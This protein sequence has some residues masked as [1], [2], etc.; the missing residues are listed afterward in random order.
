MNKS[1]TIDSSILKNRLKTESQ[2]TVKFMV[3]PFS[4]DLIRVWKSTYIKPNNSDEV[5][6]LIDKF[7]IAFFP[8]W[9]KIDVCKIT[10]FTLVFEGLPKNCKSFDLIEDALEDGG[11]HFKNIKRNANDVYILEI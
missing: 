5:Y 7:N 6:K 10:W 1:A 8:K 11:F 4:A 2:V 9:T 3:A